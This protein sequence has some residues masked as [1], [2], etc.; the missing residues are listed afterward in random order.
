MHSPWRQALDSFPPCD[1]KGR[2]LESMPYPMQKHRLWGPTVII[3]IGCCP[4]T[5]RNP[6]EA[7]TRSKNPQ[8]RLAVQPGGAKFLTDS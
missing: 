2:L 4:S 5:S 6:S 8:T 7:R 1:E 3:S